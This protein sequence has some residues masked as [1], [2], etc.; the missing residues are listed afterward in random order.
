MKQGLE[1]LYRL[2][3][4]DDKVIEIENLIK[5]IPLEIKKLEDERDGKATIIKNSKIKLEENV[6]KREKLEKELLLVKEK[7]NKYK[8]QM[9][10]A[11]TNKEYQGFNVEIKYEEDNIAKIEEKIIEQ[12][13][14]SD[15]IMTEI[16]ESESEFDKIVSD[17]NK[18]IKDLNSNLKYHQTK[19]DDQIKGK[20]KLRTEI[21]PKLLK[22]YDNLFRNKY[23]KAISFVETDFCGVCN[24]KIRPQLFNQLISEPSMF[25]C[26]SC[27]RILFKEADESNEEDDAKS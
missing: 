27:G 2:Q 20:D 8:E 3:Q 12:M 15:E 23:G 18:K 11:T 25:L 16:R 5:E 4:F 26:E 1:V 22:T 17:Y 9:N 10:K 19:R 21:K 14:E 24:V 7:I 6:K 13:L